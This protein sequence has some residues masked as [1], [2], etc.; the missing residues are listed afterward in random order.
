MDDHAVAATLARE[1]GS[2]LVDIRAGGGSE[3]DRRSNEL[4]LRRLAERPDP[5]AQHRGCRT[6]RRHTNVRYHVRTSV[7]PGMVAR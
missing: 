7:K 5:R 3:G 6:H 1:A 2:L 4:L